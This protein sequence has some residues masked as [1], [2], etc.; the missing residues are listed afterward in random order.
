MSYL[1]KRTTSFV[2]TCSDVEGADIDLQGIDGML[3]TWSLV[4][5]N[6]TMTPYPIIASR[7]LHFI[8]SSA[9]KF[10]VRAE[11]APGAGAPDWIE[12]SPAMRNEL[13]T[14]I[15]HAINRAPRSIAGAIIGRIPRLVPY[16]DERDVVINLSN[17]YYGKSKVSVSRVF[18]VEGELLYRHAYDQ[19]TLLYLMR[20]VNPGD[21][22][23]HRGEHSVH[24]VSPHMVGPR[25]NVIAFEPGPFR[26]APS[27]PV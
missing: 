25:R 8:P 5:E 12:A 22:A 11:A 2:I 24:H 21:F 20:L 18:R 13:K 27:S 26:S 16:L 3:S 15:R 6:A 14:I 7:R 10:Y 4:V 23:R 17:P 9:M 1:L 19:K